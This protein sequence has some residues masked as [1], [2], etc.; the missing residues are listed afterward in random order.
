MLASLS[1]GGTPTAL[2]YPQSG[3]L[4]PLL[5]YI[6]VRHAG[7]WADGFLTLAAQPSATLTKTQDALRAMIA[8]ARVG[9]TVAALERAAREK[10]GGIEI[11]PSARKLV[12]GI[13]LS[14]EESEAEPDGVSRLEEGRIYTLRAG[15]RQSANDS[16]LLSAMIEPKTGRAEVLWSSL[17]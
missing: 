1:N 7:Y 17:D 15:A 6:A 14:L 9:A 2:D 8:E 5:A 4:D 3:K 12:S 10:L 13:G 16:A 11:H